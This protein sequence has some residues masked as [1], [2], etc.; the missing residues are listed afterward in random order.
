LPPAD[1]HLPEDNQSLK[2]MIGS[3]LRE[4][5]EQKRYADE[6]RVQN[7]ELQV[8]N[9]RLQLQLERYKKWYYGPAAEQRGDGADVA[10]IL[11]SSG[12]QARQPG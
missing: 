1:G 8:E 12:A 5:D 11:R 2:A 7:E 10:G 9:L 3:L 4:R 6:L